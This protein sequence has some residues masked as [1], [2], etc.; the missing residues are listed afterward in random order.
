MYNSNPNQR[1]IKTH[2]QPTDDK[3]R[4]N[5]YTKIN[6]NALQEAMKTLKPYTF[7]LWLYLSKNKDNH[8][9]WLSKVDYLSWANVGTSSYYNA[10]QELVDKHYLI[11]D[12]NKPNHYDFYEIPQ[13]SITTHKS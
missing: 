9:F 6:L 1:S 12:T 7:E 8:F 4:D 3:E 2:K 13:I 11:K 5:Y 10:F